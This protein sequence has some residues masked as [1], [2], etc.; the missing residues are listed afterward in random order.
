MAK[1]MVME[2]EVIMSIELL[3]KEHLSSLKN[4]IANALD[5][6]KIV[7]P[8]IGFETS[9]LLAK[10]ISGNSV[11]CTVITRFYREDFLSHVSSLE[12]LKML[13]EAGVEVY[14]LKKLHSKLY[15]FDGDL[16]IIGSANFTMGGF[17]FNHELSLLIEEEPSLISKLSNY[18]DELLNNIK[19]TGDW[20]LTL[21]QIENEITEVDK[22]AKQRKDKKTTYKNGIQFGAEL[23][24]E[25]I[26]QEKDEIEDIVRE[27][28]NSEFDQGIW[29]KFEGTGTD[30]F[31]PTEKYSTVK[32]KKNQKHITFFPRNPRGVAKGD[33]LY[34]SALSWDNNNTATPM[35]T[36][37]ARTHG[38][39][40][41]NVADKDYISEYGWMQDYPYYCDLYDI[42]IINTE[43]RNCISLD[44]LIREQGPNL[45][46]STIG[47]QLSIAELKT[48][49]H[50]KSHIRLSPVAKSYIDK[51]FDSLGLKYGLIK[52]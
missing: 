28:I 27:H 46:P 15:I 7:S 47:K 45:Y 33:Y 11:K 10:K 13:V 24:E 6:I 36:A 30:R 50:Q 9:K 23:K 20:R 12:G 1:I 52:F 4:S 22:L 34:L 35:I 2:V 44:N 17:R 40:A 25:E 39:K 5:I 18:Y 48:R 19:S 3:D 29:L 41:E 16:S 26:G 51:L 31:D 8:F 32:L 42:E 14:A 38:F 43:I 49:H 37:R 21:Q